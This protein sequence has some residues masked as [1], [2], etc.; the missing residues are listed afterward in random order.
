[1]AISAITDEEPEL[2]YMRRLSTEMEAITCSV[3]TG[4]NRVTVTL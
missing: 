2:I 1:V 3:T 4:N